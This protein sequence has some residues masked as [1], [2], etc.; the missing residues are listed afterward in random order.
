MSRHAS[1]SG[2]S[3]RVS[4]GFYYIPQLV[5]MS[6]SAQYTSWRTFNTALSLATTMLAPVVQQCAVT[7][8]SARICTAD[9]FKYECF[10]KQCKTYYVERYW[11]GSTS[12][13]L[14]NYDDNGWMPR[15]SFR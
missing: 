10:G 12:T 5:K 14:V 15:Q 2:S 8:R 1:P 4:R 7:E 11:S 13:A 6:Y 3:V 9:A